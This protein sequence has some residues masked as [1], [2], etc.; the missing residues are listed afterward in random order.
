M[1]DEVKRLAPTHSCA[2]FN[3]GLKILE[4]EVGYGPH[5]IPQLQAVSDFLKSEYPELHIR[6]PVPFKHEARGLVPRLCV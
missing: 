6:V 2:E 3:R 1:Y 5:A 4:Q